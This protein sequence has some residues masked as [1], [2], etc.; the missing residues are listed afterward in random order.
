M[1]SACTT[2]H[3]MQ[4]Q[5]TL[6]ETQ[7]THGAGIQASQTSFSIPQEGIAPH[8]PSSTEVGFRPFDEARLLANFNNRSELGRLR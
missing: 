3:C 4:R 6:E 8:G 1:A 5:G 2:R 7:I